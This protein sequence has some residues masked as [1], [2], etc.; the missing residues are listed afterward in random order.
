M[1]QINRHTT[2][3]VENGGPVH[4]LQVSL[5]QYHDHTSCHQCQVL[6]GQNV[7]MSTSGLTSSSQKFR[8]FQQSPIVVFMCMRLLLSTH[9]R[10]LGY[11]MV[12]SSTGSSR[13]IGR[14]SHLQ[15]RGS[16]THPF[17]EM[18]LLDPNAYLLKTPSSITERGPDTF[19]TFGR[20]PDDRPE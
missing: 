6:L 18:R 1:M 12:S 14:I 11:L 19:P 13:D 2:C 15:N 8:S 9:R 3:S 4:V 16:A 17:Y 5:P 20:F 10:R 7:N